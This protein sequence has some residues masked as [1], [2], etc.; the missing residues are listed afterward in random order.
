MAFR[1]KTATLTNMTLTEFHRS[2][3]I[4]VTFSVRGHLIFME[5]V[6]VIVRA[7]DV[8]LH[9]LTWQCHG[10]STG[11]SHSLLIQE[12][13]RAALIGRLAPGWSHD[14]CTG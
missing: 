8:A 7:Q 13:M 4:L 14:T 5:G 10:K 11:L 3:I 9:L 2:E 12:K 6:F 1:V